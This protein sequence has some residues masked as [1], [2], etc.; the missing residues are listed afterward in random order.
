MSN[1]DNF[2]NEPVPKS[3]VSSLILMN[4]PEHMSTP[5]KIPHI[6]KHIKTF[7]ESMWASQYNNIPPRPANR[8]GGKPPKPRKPPKLPKPWSN[9]DNTLN[10]DMVYGLSMRSVFASV[11][12]PLP[13][14]V[15]TASFVL[16]VQLGPGGQSTP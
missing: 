1:V 14:V 16:S 4:L 10:G 12:V 3:L 13:S 8:G 7:L 9:F 11:I 5:N 2:W 6:S 15:S